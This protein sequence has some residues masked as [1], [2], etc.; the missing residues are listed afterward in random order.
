MLESLL[1]PLDNLN[2]YLKRLGIP[3][4]LQHVIDTFAKLYRLLMLARLTTKAASKTALHFRVE[5]ETLDELAALAARNSLAES[6]IRSVAEATAAL[7]K[8]RE[9]GDTIKQTLAKKQPVMRPYLFAQDLPPGLMA[10]GDLEDLLRQNAHLTPLFLAQFNQIWGLIKRAAEIRANLSFKASS[11]YRGLS[12]DNLSHRDFQTALDVYNYSLEFFSSLC[13][14]DPEVHLNLCKLEHLIVFAQLLS[15]EFDIERA[16]AALTLFAN[17]KVP[18]GNP[19]FLETLR[20]STDYFDKLRQLLADEA[21]VWTTAHVEEYS[22]LHFNSGLVSADVLPAPFKR[23]VGFFQLMNC[24]SRLTYPRETL[25]SQDDYIKLLDLVYAEP[26]IR[27]DKELDTLIHKPLKREVK[28]LELRTAVEHEGGSRLY[29][30]RFLEEKYRQQLFFNVASLDLFLKD[31]AEELFEFRRLA[32]RVLHFED[33]LSPMEYFEWGSSENC[34]S[35]FALQY[36]PAPDAEEAPVLVRRETPAIKDAISDIMSPQVMKQ[37]GELGRMEKAEVAVVQLA[38][39]VYAAAQ[40]STNQGRFSPLEVLDFVKYSAGPLDCLRMYGVAEPTMQEARRL[41]ADCV[42][43]YKR[44]WTHLHAFLDSLKHSS[45]KQGQAFLYKDCIDT[46]QALTSFEEVLGA[47]LQVPEGIPEGQEQFDFDKARSDFQAVAQSVLKRVQEGYEEYK[48]QMGE[49]FKTI[50]PNLREYYAKQQEARN[51][52]HMIIFSGDRVIDPEELIQDHD[53]NPNYDEVIENKITLRNLSTHEKLSRAFKKRILE[54]VNL[55]RDLLNDPKQIDIFAANLEHSYE[56]L[57]NIY[58]KLRMIYIEQFLE[59]HVLIGK[60]IKRY[61]SKKL[62]FD[63]LQKMIMEFIKENNPAGENQKARPPKPPKAETPAAEEGEKQPEAPKTETKK[64]KRT[65][66]LVKRETCFMDEIYNNMKKEMKTKKKATTTKAAAKPRS[67][68][69]K[70]PNIA[71]FASDSETEQKEPPAPKPNVNPLFPAP[72][73]LLNLFFPRDNLITFVDGQEATHFAG[74][75]VYTC[76]DAQI[77]SSISTLEKPPQFF[78]GKYVKL[79]RQIEAEIE[80]YD[81]TKT[82]A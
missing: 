62:K 63:E 4:S 39:L 82:Y 46:G 65:S 22:Q 59:E 72:G 51:E 57:K 12:S 5:P 11:I 64:E 50:R 76:E 42:A 33:E 6:K 16:Y 18:C 21:T 54:N 60:V 17:T 66:R 38:V 58:T 20:Q 7:A 74:A 27:V 41:I 49:L 44:V 25:F 71:V 53:A 75:P 56:T 73:S 13:F 30:S 40:L 70:N 10:K 19:Q 52:K 77:I 15:L 36:A 32:Q 35:I 48:A 61:N 8:I 55:P 67:D 37:L 3:L 45:S 14:F 34:F 69:E 29:F 78:Y 80:D 31:K 81:F 1:N 68:E 23:I 24:L 2:A 43:V 47:T 9:F 28:L 26:N 79:M